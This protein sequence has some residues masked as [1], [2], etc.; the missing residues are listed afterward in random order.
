MQRAVQKQAMQILFCLCL[1]DWGRCL[2]A[3]SY[4]W[5]AN[6]VKHWTTPPPATRGHTRSIVAVQGLHSVAN[7][8]E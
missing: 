7:V 3:L 5:L 8:I 2:A 6:K 1:R 4:F